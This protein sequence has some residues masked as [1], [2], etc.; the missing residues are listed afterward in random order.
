MVSTLIILAVVV[1]SLVLAGT[2][3]WRRHPEVHSVGDWETKKHDIDVEAFRALV[4]LNDERRL[5]GCLSSKQFHHFQRRRIRLAISIL[6]LIEENVG[7][8]MS[9]AQRARMM[10]D[11]VLRRRADEVIAVAF[12]LRIKLLLV[13]LYLSAK[14]LFPTWSLCLPT[15]EPKYKELLDRGIQ[16]QQYGQQALT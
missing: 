8:L 10:R 15:F 5:R 7:M 3:L 16:F 12:Q 4:D 1:L 9:L 11:P 2:L 13:R 6:R 14:W